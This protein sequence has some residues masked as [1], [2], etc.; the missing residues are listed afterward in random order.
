MI[1]SCDFFSVLPSV[2][3][4]EGQ[5][6]FLEVEEGSDL[7]LSVIITDFNVPITDITWTQ[8]GNALTSGQ[9]RVTITNTPMMTAPVNST[10]MITSILPNEA[11]SYVVTAI[12]DAGS[13]T[14]MFNVTVTC[15]EIIY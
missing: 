11:G 14:F 12:N 15:K 5:V 2:L 9:G 4:G 10:L 13:D 8:I 3:L 1:F 6:A 7:T